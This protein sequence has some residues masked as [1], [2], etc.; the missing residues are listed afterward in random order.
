MEEPMKAPL[1]IEWSVAAEVR[2]DEHGGLATR[3]PDEVGTAMG[4][5]AGD[6]LCWTGFVDGTVEVWPVAKSPYSSLADPVLE[7]E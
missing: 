7:T 3:I 4:L 1:A 6:V 5:T 2:S